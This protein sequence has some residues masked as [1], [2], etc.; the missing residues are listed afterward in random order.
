MKELPILVS[1]RR[2]NVLKRLLS[3][4][5]RHELSHWKIIMYF[6]RFSRKKVADLDVGLILLYF[7]K[8]IKM[9]QKC[10]LRYWMKINSSWY[11]NLLRY[12]RTR[13]HYIYNWI[14]WHIWFMLKELTCWLEFSGRQASCRILEKQVHSRWW[15]Q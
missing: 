14:F 13:Y 6:K 2:K 11:R 12:Q 8:I 3:P 9:R 1:V 4:N 15:R 10:I 5:F 7:C